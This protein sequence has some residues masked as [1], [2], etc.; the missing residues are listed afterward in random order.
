M[1]EV[2]W[3]QSTTDESKTLQGR[4]LRFASTLSI[5]VFLTGWLLLAVAPAATPYLN[6][7][8]EIVIRDEPWAWNVEGL[9]SQFTLDPV[10]FKSGT[11]SLRFH[12]THASSQTEAAQLFP[13]ELVRGKHVHVSGWI[14]TENVGAAAA[15]LWWYEVVG[16]NGTISSQYVPAPG[17]PPGSTEWT[18]YEENCA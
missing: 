8:F 16:T 12:N 14:R 2:A 6:L 5:L 3:R 1:T 4:A 18:R 17:L 7:D 10:V 13:I 11:R 15:G 9:A